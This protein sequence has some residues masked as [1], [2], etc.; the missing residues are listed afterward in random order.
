MTEQFQHIRRIADL[1]TADLTG[2]ITESERKELEAWK[3]ASPENS[4]IYERYR[5]KEFVACKFEFLRR[6]DWCE[7]NRDF[8]KRTDASLRRRKIQMF[9]RYAGMIALLFIA[10][11]IFYLN[12]DDRGKT[13]PLV[14]KIQPGTFKAILT[15]PDG[16][17]VDISDTTYLAYV[18]KEEK[19][20]ISPKEGIQVP[21]EKGIRYH[22]ITI[23]RGGEYSVTLSDGSQ[24]K[25]N[26]GSEIRIPENFDKRQR[27]VYMSGEIYFEVAR[28][29]TVPFVVHTRQGMIKVLGTSF[30][31]R[32][33][34]DEK[35]LETTLVSGKVAFDMNDENTYL[36]P[37]E[38]LRLNKE[39]GE[40]TVQEVDIN[41]YCSW[42]DG[43]FVFEKQRLE[44]I[45]NT[46]SRWYDIRVFYANQSAKDI[47]F[48]GNIKRYS[49]LDQIVDML[50]LMNKID[51]EINGN[52]VFVK[53]NE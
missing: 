17:K 25:M 44:D 19:T 21:E 10:S 22:T 9:Y 18:K 40:T 24:L 4:H 53:S 6:N 29:M 37:G 1:I 34:A 39:N 15:R 38:Q 43:R 46:I 52:N 45:M 51:I 27:E 3:N 32:D 20:V 7:A 13:L 50:K 5:S 49:D 30:N 2:K 28:D 11:G 36:E 48:T 26:S 8:S 35:F 23:P 31:V 14:Q 12:R 41:L 33:Y 47:L 42:K 16:T